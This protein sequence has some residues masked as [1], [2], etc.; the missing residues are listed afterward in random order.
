MRWKFVPITNEMYVIPGETA[1][2]FFN[3]KNE[4][5][6][7]IVGISTYSVV[8]AKTAQYVFLLEFL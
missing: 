2:A 3:A 6:G 7:D 5:D 4:T 1:L 8:P